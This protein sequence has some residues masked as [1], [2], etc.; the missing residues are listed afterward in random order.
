MYPLRALSPDSKS[1][2]NEPQ[3]TLRLFFIVATRI[4][5]GRF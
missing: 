3:W 5:E 1:Y 2:V 4:I